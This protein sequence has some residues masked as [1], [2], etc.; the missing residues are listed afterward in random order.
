RELLAAMG[1]GFRN[2]W[3]LPYVHAR[4]ADEDPDTVE[5]AIDAAGGL[6]FPGLEAALV[7][8]L[9][10]ETPRP[11]RLA[12]IRAL[13]R[14][15]AR[16]AAPRLGDLTAAAPRTAAAPLPALTET[17]SP[18]A[19]AAAAAACADDPPREL[20]LAAVRYLA[21]MGRDE[22]LPVLRRLGRDADAELRLVAAQ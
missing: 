4:L 7:T 17:R 3:L 19:A 18:A 16:S 2:L 12:A 22:V 11:L 21:E 9:D 8:F 13:G 6:G 1:R 20:L 5:A 10:E 14:A 15:G